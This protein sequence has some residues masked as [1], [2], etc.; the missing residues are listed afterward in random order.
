MS[1]CSAV[2]ASF[3]GLPRNSSAY[4]EQESKLLKRPQDI[5]KPTTTSEKKLFGGLLS[6]LKGAAGA[7][8][9]SST[10]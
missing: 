5:L 3:L 4:R 2:A 7:L 9:G 8:G 1:H 10:L 6:H